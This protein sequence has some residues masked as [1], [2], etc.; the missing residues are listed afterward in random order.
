MNVSRR[1]LGLLVIILL[2]LTAE[3]DDSNDLVEVTEADGPEPV[4]PFPQPGVQWGSAQVWS[5]W[6]SVKDKWEC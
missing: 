4:L 6:V 2:W 1:D 5:F 3:G